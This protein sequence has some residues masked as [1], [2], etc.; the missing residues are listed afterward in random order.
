MNALDEVI[1]Y[2]ENKVSSVNTNNPK[3]NSG[4]VYL[5]ENYELDDLP[6][7][8]D[9]SIAIIQLNFT[10]TNSEVEAG[11]AKLTNVSM[12]IGR[13]ICKRPAHYENTG[14]YDE[15]V[16]DIRIG[17][18]F[19]EA[20]YN[21]GF[22][23]LYYPQ[24]RNGFHI[25]TATNKWPKLEDA[26][27]DIDLL[28]RNT[29]TEKPPLI[30]KMHQTHCGGIEYPVVKKA[31]PTDPI[32]IDSPW[33]TAVNKLQQTGWK[34]NKRILE[35]LLANKEHFVSYEELEVTDEITKKM[36][37][38]RRSKIVEW[39]FIIEKAKSL[40]HTTFY[41]LIDADYRGRLYYCEP[42]LSF[43][44]SDL[45]RG[46]LQFSRG[47]PMDTYGLYWLAVHTACS[48]NQ[49]Y[50]I[51][52]I[53]DWCT[54]DYKSYLKEE[55]LESI[56]TDKMTLA[57]RVEWVNQNMDW[58]REAGRNSKIFNKAEKPISF[59]ACCLEWEDYHQAVAEDKIHRTHLPIPIDG[60]NNG[61]QHLGA[62][63]KDAKTGKLVGLIPT[64]IQKDFYVQTA[65]ELYTLTDG[66]LREI[67]DQ[68]PM[69][70]I[71]KG[72]SKRGSMTRAYSAGAGKIGENMWFDCRT[73]DFHKLYGITEEDCAGFAKLLIKAISTVCSGPLQTMGYLQNLAGV[74]IKEGQTSMKWTTPSGFRVNYECF[75]SKKCK[76]RGTISGYD[77]YNKQ[78][79]VQHIAQVYTDFPDV[80]GFMCGISPNY[81][82][83]MDA[84]HMALV[85]NKWNGDFGAVHD[86]FST[87]ATDVELLLA[88]TK[89]EFIDM[90]DVSNYFK[91]IE[92]QLIEDMD[93]VTLERPQLGNLNIEEIEDSD[94]F[95]A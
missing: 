82:H 29:V 23:D 4:A 79:Q 59:L 41:Q 6:Q 47:K 11:E 27:A 58:I 63:S 81:I 91:I 1:I 46:M 53:P 56:S 76:T 55:N 71:R 25:I 90:Y 30:E 80:R 34:I 26:L 65:K 16:K 74:A 57:D 19:V 64:E 44:G 69:K 36:E 93:D 62:I 3:A 32:D 51:E 86:S 18:L 9:D 13:H 33:V 68:M 72:I 88:H 75:Y 5:K 73:E 42:F 15:W 52:E 24:R 66:R 61:W 48:Y 7:L 37:L 12:T 70:H 85:I 92:A 21:T 84:A 31:E 10:R 38:K 43:Q 67:L 60:S 50:K 54:S 20:L 87:H 22:I 95:F 14:I 28:L 17:D 94:Y 35:A 78:C 45:S 8:L 77:K 83:S 39:G 40:T 89:R 2:L 49:S